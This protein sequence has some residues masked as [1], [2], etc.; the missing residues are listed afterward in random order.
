MKGIGLE[1]PRFL[2]LGVFWVMTS[3]MEAALSSGKLVS[4]HNTT[5]RHNPKDLDL[6]LHR[7]ESVSRSGSHIKLLFSVYPRGRCISQWELRTY[8]PLWRST[9]VGRG[10]L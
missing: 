1:S 5:Q 6:N 2:L 4:Y 3:K 9:R 7:R 8:S 10:W